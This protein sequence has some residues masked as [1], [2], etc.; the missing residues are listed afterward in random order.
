MFI[1]AFTNGW[2]DDLYAREAH[3]TPPDRLY[4]L[5]DGAFVPGLHRKLAGGRKAL[6]FASLPG[7]TQEVAD[8]SPFLTLIDPAHRILKA[9]LWRCDR[10]PMLSVIGTPE[11]LQQLAKRLAAWCVVEVDG[12][13]FNF[14]FPDTRRLP[15]IFDT[16]HQTQR[17]QLLGPATSW[18][19]IGR[20]GRWHAL[21][22]EGSGA[23]VA[24]GP[25]LDERQF[26]ALAGDSHADEL[27][28]LMGDRGDDV[29]SRPSRTHALLST[30]LSGARAAGMA[31]GSLIGWCEWF[32][33]QDH[34]CEESAVADMLQMWR[35][36]SR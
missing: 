28:A 21:P 17:A 14:R 3:Q 13:R 29:Y 5:V 25:M 8:V 27:M 23:E 2:L 11:S 18:T 6:L 10:W 1:D 12:Q 26:A 7:C 19:Y 32:W 30:A 35:T 15:A 34:L 16:L 9:L 33:K 24:D 4:V 20:D 31:D 36:V 22:V